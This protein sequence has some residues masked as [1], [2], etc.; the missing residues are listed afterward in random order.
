MVL[1]CKKTVNFANYED[2]LAQDD[3]RF[4]AV[5]LS[6]GTTGGTNPSSV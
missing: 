2:A 3:Q 5:V 6:A 4:I 1:L